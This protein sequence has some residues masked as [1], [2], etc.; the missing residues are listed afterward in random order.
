MDIG[1]V[2]IAAEVTAGITPINYS[3]PPYNLLRYC[4][5]YQGS[6]TPDNTASIQAVIDA[7]EYGETLFIP[8]LPAN[9]YFRIT[10]S[11]SLPIGKSLNVIG[12]SPTNSRIHQVTSGQSV[13]TSAS[14][15]GSPAQNLIIRDLY[16]TGIPPNFLTPRLGVMMIS[17]VSD[18]KADIYSGVQA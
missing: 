9:H 3:Y 7:M 13:F 2:R 4:V 18:G 12:E 5:P 10:S 11:L 17:E 15:F 8:A 16:L 6:G 14:T 1:F